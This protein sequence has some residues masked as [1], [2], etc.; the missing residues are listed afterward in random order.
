MKYTIL[1]ILSFFIVVTSFSQKKYSN[2]YEV[3]FIK[4]ENGKVYCTI[5]TYCKNE[6][7]CLENAKVDAIKTALFRGFTSDIKLYPIIRNLDIEKEN[8]NYFDN[9]FKPNGR[10]LNFIEYTQDDLVEYAEIYRRKK[11]FAT[12][13]IILRDNL[14][15]EM[16]NQKII[17]LLDNGF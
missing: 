15:K 11:K 10:Y 8:K 7:Q 3:D 14:I 1:F 16:Q 9:F 5:F 17:K 6:K 12:N 2:E 4:S 13:I